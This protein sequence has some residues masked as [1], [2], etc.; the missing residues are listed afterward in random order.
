MPDAGEDT[1]V[2]GGYG[3][4]PNEPERRP[5][6]SVPEG[7]P[8]RGPRPERSEPSLDDAAA[9]VLGALSGEEPSLAMQR[10]R[11]DPAFRREVAELTPVVGLLPSVLG[12]P[13]ADRLPSAAGPVVRDVAPSLDLRARILSQVAAEARPEPVHRDRP[14]VVP[15]PPRRSPTAV[16]IGTQR[17]AQPT[18]PA[19]R[20]PRRGAPPPVGQGRFGAGRGANTWLTAVMAAVIVLFAIAAIALQIRNATLSDRVDA[21]TEQRT[22]LD[23]EAIALQNEV[24]LA[25]SQSNASAWVLNPSD[26]NPTAQNA[27]GTVFYSYREE[28][29]AAEIRGLAPPAADQ[30]Y[31]LWY[32]NVDGSEQPRS[33]GVMTYSSD[34]VAFFTT[35][36]VPYDF[37]EFAV[38][39]EPAGGS[40]Q[41]TTVILRGTLSAAG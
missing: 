17:P 32:L 35:S 11:R 36:D 25:N 40:E 34:G 27:T 24:A 19:S 28:S 33:A 21:L 13:D 20:E 22:Q 29:V 39:V 6:G 38:S 15:A 12:L 18:L 5:N 4:H 8:S 26:A 3:N 2:S 7:M 16:P 1:A 30:A 37:K 9:L 23:Q 14:A 10:L 41:P 31:Q